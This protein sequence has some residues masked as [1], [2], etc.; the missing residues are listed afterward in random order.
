MSTTELHVIIGTGPLGL[1]T[2]RTLLTL[3]RRVRL[4]NRSGQAPAAPAAVEVVRG[5]ARDLASVTAL[6]RGATAVYQCAQPAYHRWVQEFPALQAAILGAARANGAR[7]IVAENL[8][9]YGDPQ[10]RPLTEATPYAAHTRKGRVRQL[11]TETLFAADQAGEIQ[12]A[13]AR[14][15]NFFGPDDSLSTGMVF[16]PVLAGKPATL[17]GR[18]DQPHTYTY[19][20]DFGRTL[21]LL[22]TST[23]GLGRAWHVPSAPP[24]T[25]TELI[26]LVSAAA[27][28]PVRTRVAGKFLLS[29]LGLFNPLI[30]ESV[31]MLYEHTHPFVMDSSA[32]SRTFGVQPTPLAEAVHATVD[33]CRA[34]V[35]QGVAAHR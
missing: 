15:A 10:G 14:G 17:L 13:S 2:A 32:F 31:E 28:R 34:A 3:G 27:E 29:A 21:A 12:A 23:T 25:Q 35:L 26:D 20:A 6:T 5:D 22:G 8:Y 9:M 18:L 33:W 4:V 19:V 30:A 24:V 7:L 1:W 11:M 16:R